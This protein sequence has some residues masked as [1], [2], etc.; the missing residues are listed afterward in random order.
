MDNHNIRSVQHLS[1]RPAVGYDP[2]APVKIIYRDDSEAFSR[3]GSDVG[4]GG[5]LAWRSENGDDA[6]GAYQPRTPT[7][8]DFSAAIQTHLDAKARERQYDNI[9]TAIGY[10]GDPNPVFDAEADALFAWRSAVW[11]YATAELAKVQAGE[12]SVPTIGD[13]VAELPAFAWPES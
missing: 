9:H 8:A 11:T 7:A 6:A 4:N 10:R 12:R 3:W 5:V 13:F 1:P 2:S